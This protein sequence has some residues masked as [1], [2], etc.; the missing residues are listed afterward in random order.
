MF[1]YGIDSRIQW[2]MGSF[3]NG[4]VLNAAIISSS[5]DCLWTALITMG[6]S[7]NRRFPRNRRSG[8]RNETVISFTPP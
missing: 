4:G 3:L 1:W 5:L 7:S 2:F 8:Y 6:R